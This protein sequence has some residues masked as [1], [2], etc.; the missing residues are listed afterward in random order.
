[1]KRFFKKLRQSPHEIRYK[2]IVTIASNIKLWKNNGNPFSELYHCLANHYPT[3]L[4]QHYWAI[5]GN[6]KVLEMFQN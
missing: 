2:K 3:A 5:N 1:M 4:R 6:N